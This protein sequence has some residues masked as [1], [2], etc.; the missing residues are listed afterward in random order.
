MRLWFPL[1]LL[2]AVVVL[3][4]TALASLVLALA[5]PVLMVV[6]GAAVIMSLRGVGAGLEL[7]RGGFQ[8]LGHAFGYVGDVGALVFLRTEDERELADSLFPPLLVRVQAAQFI[9][10]H[11]MQRAVA[12]ELG[13]EPVEEFWLC[14]DT[15]LGIGTGLRD[16]RRIRFLVVGLVLLRA[17]DPQQL[18][19]ALAHEFGHQKG[20]DLW[21]G[22]WAR[23]FIHR[24]LFAADRFSWL[25]P[26]R[27]SAELSLLLVGAGYFPWSRAKE[28][29]ADR[30][31]ARLAGPEAVAAGLRRLRE[32]GPAAG[33]SLE[34][35]LGEA[36]RKGKAPTRLVEAMGRVFA[37]IPAVERHRLAVRSEGDPLDLG[38]RTHPT[39]A[40][41]AAALAH[42]PP[43]APAAVAPFDRARLGQLDE[44][45]TRQWLA[46]YRRLVPVEDFFA[47]PV[48]EGAPPL[49]PQDEDAPLELDLDGDWRKR[50]RR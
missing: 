46:R 48:P 42:L 18:R 34:V 44:R 35:V 32:V 13:L 50:R 30:W 1:I 16:G 36:E 45:L 31:A 41:R 21:L 47:P 39:D 19:A 49:P 33:Y 11:R 9:E 40:Q 4:V 15:A 43:V 37:A 20:G 38:G 17:L 22:R 8:L 2:V 26:A 29:A 23:H 10:L 3:L 12:E 6:G 27:W 25:N 14:P 24:M 28:F 5:F 7:M